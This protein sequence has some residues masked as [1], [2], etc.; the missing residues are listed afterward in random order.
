MSVSRLLV[1]KVRPAWTKSTA[2]AAFVLRDTPGLAAKSVSATV[3]L[4]MQFLCQYLRNLN[5]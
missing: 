2:T 3:P 4:K 1:P 5:V